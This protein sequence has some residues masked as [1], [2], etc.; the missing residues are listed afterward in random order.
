ME[1]QP[2][3]ETPIAGQG[4]GGSGDQQVGNAEK[5]NKERGAVH[6]L[7]NGHAA[8]PA[9]NGRVGNGCDPA[10]PPAAAETAPPAASPKSVGAPPEP[11]LNGSAHGN[12]LDASTEL[13]R[14]DTDAALTFL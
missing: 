1:R 2:R 9:P 4:N 7:P 8:E 10:A 14:I 11:H 13:P 5:I 12:G 3:K 6:P